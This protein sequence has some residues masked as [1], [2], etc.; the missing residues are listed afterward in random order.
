[1]QTANAY[2]R[3]AKYYAKYRWD[4]DPRA[5]EQIFSVTGL[6]LQSVVADVG[7]GTGILTRHF[8]GRVQKIY[9]I[10]P[11]NAMRQEAISLLDDSP[12]VVVIGAS[13]E[14]TGLPDHSVDLI[15]AAQAVHW[16]QPYAARA[17]FQR[18]LK[19]CGWLALLRNSS[20]D[21]AISAEM[22]AILTPAY[23]VT[24]S[25]PAPSVHV[26]ETF[27]F[28]C[29]GCQQFHFAYQS[30]QNLEQ[31]IG[32]AL[33]A[34]FTPD[35]TDPAFERFV[36]AATDIFNR[37]CPDGINIIRGETHLTIGHLSADPS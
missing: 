11:N 15:T 17:E 25:H 2:A 24:P 33:S 23:G 18:I 9:A 7:A 3:K 1:M 12:D 21:D 27:Y 30:E 26:P 34:S 32:A 13:A 4:Y 28:G 8:T 6:G 5:T 37:H 16:F 35:E 20:R 10:E 22:N 36:Q 19:P 31:F 14:T 29:S